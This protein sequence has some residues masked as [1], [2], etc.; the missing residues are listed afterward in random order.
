MESYKLQ[1]INTL[2]RRDYE[3]MTMSELAVGS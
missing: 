2:G 3:P 1:I